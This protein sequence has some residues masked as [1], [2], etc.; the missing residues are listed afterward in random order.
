MNNTRLE[1][2]FLVRKL[3]VDGGERLRLLAAEPLA[4]GSQATAI[5]GVRDDLDK[6]RV[7][8]DLLIDAED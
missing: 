7:V 4:L 3:V 8:V 2:L 1:A 6:A 5:E